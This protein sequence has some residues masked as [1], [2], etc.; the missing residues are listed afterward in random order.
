MGNTI[1]GVS[2]YGVAQ[3]AG[4]D[5]KAKTTEETKKAEEAAAVNTAGKAAE[6]TDKTTTKTEGITLEISN[7]GQEMAN[8]VKKMSKEDRTALVNQLKADQETYQKRFLAMVQDLFSKQATAFGN[9]ENIWKT[10]ASGK[11][12]VDEATRA[13]AQESISEDGYYGVKQTSERMFQFALALTGGDEDKMK[14][15]QEAVSKGYKQAEKTW[16]GELPEISK[17]TLD[18]TNKLFEDYYNRDKTQDVATE[19]TVDPYKV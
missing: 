4:Y 3:A 5:T 19:S 14:E 15:M 9:S 11:F 12:E 17:K 8:E 10:L 13:E 2:A 18:A 16:G 6:E 7:R 1:G